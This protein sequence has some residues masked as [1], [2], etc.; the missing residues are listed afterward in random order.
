MS[1]QARR[2]PPSAHAVA[3][4]A[5]S[6]ATSRLSNPKVVDRS[7]CTVRRRA[8][9]RLLAGAECVRYIS[10][11]PEQHPVPSLP[12]SSD[13][14]YSEGLSRRVATCPMTAI[15][16]I[17]EE[18]LAPAVDLRTNPLTGSNSPAASVNILPGVLRFG[19]KTL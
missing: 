4:L 19:G 1:V 11:G 5:M 13:V 9:L 17:L 2:L 16:P 18:C 14:C 6:N 10:Y 3:H 8:A 15:A 12:A 7:P